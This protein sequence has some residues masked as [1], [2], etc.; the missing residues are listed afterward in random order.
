M[1]LFARNKGV[2]PKLS[3]AIERGCIRS[4]VICEALLSLWLRP[5]LFDPG[6]L[7]A[8]I[9]TM[10]AKKTRKK[11]PKAAF[12]AAVLTHVPFDGWSGIALTKAARDLDLDK[13][14]VT[15]L[16]PGGVNDVLAAYVTAADAAMLVTLDKVDMEG[17][18]IRDRIKTA[19]K[20]RIEAV[21][22]TREAERRALGY[23]ALPFN[24]PQGLGFV[25]RTVDLMWRAAGDTSTDFNFYTK[26][27][28]LGGVY[29]STLM[30]WLNDTSDDYEAT[31][32]FLDRRIEDVMQI[33][34]AK[35][36]VKKAT[37]DMPSLTKGLARLR[38]PSNTRMKP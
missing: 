33:E 38:Y 12:L 31:W 11:D 1:G 2:S 16:F 19:V 27:M 22:D 15:L 25:A 23:L 30:Y 21:A 6:R 18:R 4:G 7:P 13:G 20:A 8:H 36:K 14:E 32:A 34:K 17:L 9:Q 28:L 24:A 37:A 26:R 3:P 29:S 35:A 5:Y 10:A